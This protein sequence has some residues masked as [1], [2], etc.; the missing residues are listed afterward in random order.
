LFSKFS[1][2]SMDMRKHL[3]VGRRGRK[4][5]RGGHQKRGG[6]DPPPTS[7]KNVGGNDIPKNMSEGSLVERGMQFLLAPESLPLCRDMGSRLKLADE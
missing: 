3:F 2:L 5:E 6:K 4:N 7:L 1:V